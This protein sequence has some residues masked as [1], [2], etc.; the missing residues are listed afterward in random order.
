MTIL[1]TGATGRI[2][3]QVVAMLAEAGAEVRALTRSPEKARPTAG[4]VS[5]KGDLADI[6][7]MRAALRGVDTLF[8]LVA[9]VPDEM[10]Q[11]LSTLGLARDAGVRGIVYLSVYKGEA[12]TDVPHFTGKFAVE[13]MIADLGLPATVLRPA[14]FA[15]NDLAQKDALLK[16]GVYGMPIGHK[17]VA[18]VD[19]RD[20][21]EA[22]VKE[23]LRRERADAPLPFDAYDLVGP[24][25]L[26]GPALAAIWTEALGREVRYGGD[27]LDALE[28]R[29]R[30]FAP[31]WL[32][33]DMR[34]MV[35]RYQTDGAVGTADAVGR[36]TT[37]L[38]HPPRSNRAFAAETAAL[39]T[40]VTARPE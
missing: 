4:V 28:Q 1:V 18:F 5:V 7:S 14:Y 32:A 22:A 31:S 20:I 34:L 15:Q 9:N 40:V 16:A 26:T 39:W 37:L 25:D 2:G 29:M 8:L 3:S 38:G 33:Y 13:R 36:L 11:A 6:D 21:A 19:T 10:T 17:G 30:T 24:D 12:Y 27:D 35:R 23:L